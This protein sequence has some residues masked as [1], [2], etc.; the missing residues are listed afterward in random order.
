MMT[1]GCVS[2]RARYVPMRMD[3]VGRPSVRHTYA[4]SLFARPPGRPPARLAQTRAPM[5]IINSIRPPSASCNFE[6]AAS[7]CCDAH[8]ARHKAGERASKHTVS[9]SASI[10]SGDPAS[11]AQIH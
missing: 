11:E 10:R 3:E 4:G 9:R 2:R 7:G 6:S 5:K 8:R 1:K